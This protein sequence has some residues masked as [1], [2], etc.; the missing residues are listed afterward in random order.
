MA[1]SDAIPTEGLGQRGDI[2][3]A[4]LKPEPRTGIDPVT[5]APQVGGDD[6]EMTGER[7][8]DLPPVQLGRNCH[9]VDQYE[10]LSAAR[11]RAL[12]HPRDPTAGQFRQA[13]KGRC[14]P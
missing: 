12:P 6:T 13:G 2:V 8:E 9:P 5:M 7:R 4:V 1:V 11:A 10:C 14:L 3:S